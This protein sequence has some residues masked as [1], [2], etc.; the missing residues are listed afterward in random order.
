[1]RE[2]SIETD[3]QIGKYHILRKLGQG[4]EGVV[5]LAEDTGLNRRVALKRLRA[6]EDLGELIR[7]EAAFLRD[8]RHPM[9]PVVYDLL[10]E[11][12]WYLVMEYIEGISLHNYIEAKGS[13]REEQACLWGEALLD[14]LI[15]LHTRET[16]VIYRDL[17]PDNIMVCRD[18]SLRLIDFGAAFFKNF[19]ERRDER[20][21]WTAGYGAPEQMGAAGREA[22][23]DERS[24]IY[25]FGR[26]LYYMVTAADPGK[27]P[28]AALAP[29]LY[30]PLLS[31]GFEQM[32]A[33]CT[34]EDAD[35]RYQVAAEVWHDLRER[36][37]WRRGTGKRGFLRC[38]EKQ[39]FLAQRPA[40]T[41]SF[42]CLTDSFPI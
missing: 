22:Y 32:L 8:L 7:R 33:R 19:G 2:K 20:A 1:M 21:A 17:K 11:D 4:G 29:S 30:D 26:T 38:I 31:P 14:V 28:Y 12:G 34:M 36:R 40:R 16:P 3:K 18:G 35:E 9:L 10:F 15:Y 13:V 39:I 24:D 25:A 42:C 41:E 37:T 5:Y 23:A 6:E 27:P